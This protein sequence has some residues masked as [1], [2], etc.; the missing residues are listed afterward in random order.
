MGLFIQICYGFWSFIV[1][2]KKLMIKIYF[3]V[4]SELV[5][6]FFKIWSLLFFQ[7]TGPVFVFL[8]IPVQLKD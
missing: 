6:S 7:N 4:L 5:Y 8:K 2:P 1:V 3:I